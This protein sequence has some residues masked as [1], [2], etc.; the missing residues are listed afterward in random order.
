MIEK[1]CFTE[2]DAIIALIT[3]N[4]LT[5]QQ[6]REYIRLAKEGNPVSIE[7]IRTLGNIQGGS[8]L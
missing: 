3:H 8:I 5:I 1:S 2:E 4:G 7:E 6:A